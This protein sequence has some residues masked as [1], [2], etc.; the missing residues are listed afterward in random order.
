MI[1]RKPKLTL[2]KRG[3]GTGQEPI[4]ALP[5]AKSRADSRT[6]RKYIR[7]GL[8][9]GNFLLL[10]AVAVF[11]VNN[12]S[13]SQ[14]IRSSTV[15]SAV[16]TASSISN[17]LDELSSAKIALQAA[18]M[19]NMPEATAVKNQADSES[20]LLAVVASDD[21]VVA[22]PQIV[23]T[24][25]K[26]KHDIIRYTVKAGDTITS[27]A[28]K[29]GI[30]P[31]GVRWSNNISG[32][33]VPAGK[34]LLIPPA[35]GIVYRVKA[36]DSIDSLVSRYQA[37]RDS[38]ITVNDA[39]SGSLEVGSLVWIPNATQP[40]PTLR[41]AAASSGFSFGTSAIYG[42]NG[43]DRGYCTWWASFRRTQ[44]GNPV[45]SNLGNAITWK[46]RAGLAGLG[47]G[48]RPQKGA[49]IWTPASRG[50]GHVGFVEQVN[51]DGSVWVSDMNSRGFARMDVNSGGAGGWNRVSY[52]L[53]SPD[54]A[55]GFWYI[56]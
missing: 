3:D 50:Y 55:A 49:V 39:E 26:S 23:A 54:Q 48:T 22:K 2:L 25:L 27:I 30:A 53:L 17:P 13:A 14:T 37:N 28:T 16:S 44:I 32:E 31:N 9:S 35:N 21:S 7:W 1:I 36:G 56:Y 18:Q 34:E 33:A 15:N 42:S 20:T 51:D 19:A 29:F 5:F 4:L 10:L 41:F 12:R 11:V 52:R 38:F 46:S 40:L 8:I 43:Y 24:S 45:P 47:T 6:R